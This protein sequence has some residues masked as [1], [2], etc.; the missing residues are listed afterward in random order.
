MKNISVKLLLT[1]GL[2]NCRL[3]IFLYSA[4]VAILFDGAKW[5]GQY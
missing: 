1:G 2:R 4:L 3:K 5:F